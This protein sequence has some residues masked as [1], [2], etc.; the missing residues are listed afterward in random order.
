VSPPRLLV[1][2]DESMICDLVREV[3]LPLGF[4]VLTCTDPMEV[5]ALHDDFA[6]T[7]ILLDVVMP[8]LDGVELVQWLAKRRSEARVTIMT[9]YNPHYATFASRIGRDIG[10]GRV[11]C[12]DKPF[13]IAKLREHL[14]AQILDVAG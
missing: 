10:L 3:A 7:H 14:R 11:D 13:A 6:P 8:G 12:L 1:V 4:E 2:D 9:G 5:A